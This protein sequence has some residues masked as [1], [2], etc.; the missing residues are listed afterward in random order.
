MCFV[1]VTGKNSE[2]KKKIFKS[3]PHRL[4]HSEFNKSE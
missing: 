3:K 4:K 1:T 2:G